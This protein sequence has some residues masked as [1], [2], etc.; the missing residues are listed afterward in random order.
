MRW[1]REINE[2]KRG[3]TRKW[4]KG[5][6]KK[7][8]EM[9]LAMMCY[10]SSSLSCLCYLLCRVFLSFNPPFL[11][12]HQ[13]NKRIAWVQHSMMTEGKKKKSI[14]VLIEAKELKIKYDER[15]LPA[16]ERDEG[17]DSD[18][19]VNINARVVFK[20]FERIKLKERMNHSLEVFQTLR[21][22]DNSFR[23]NKGSIAQEL[24]LSTWWIF[25]Q[26]HGL[27]SYNFSINI[28]RLCFHWYSTPRL[29][30]AIVWTGE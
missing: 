11:C 15:T 14:R 16:R 12:C 7:A 20:V 29:I 1:G 24:F 25:L 8:R 4:W 5:W 23:I 26:N 22:G 19:I 21:N 6:M 17:I 30:K 3:M 9:N 2:H 18:Q 27:N 13:A 10:S 28:W